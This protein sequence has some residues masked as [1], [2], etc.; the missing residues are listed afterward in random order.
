LPVLHAV[1][2]PRNGAPNLPTPRTVA[3][4]Q[5]NGS[6]R[7]TQRRLY[8]ANPYVA[9]ASATVTTATRAAVQRY[10]HAKPSHATTVATASVVAR[11]AANASLPIRAHERPGEMSS[12][13][14]EA[15]ASPRR[16]QPLLSRRDVHTPGGKRHG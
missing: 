9:N 15:K 16:Q 3:T 14:H 6:V 8:R 4:L 12:F 1:T 10:N 13:K 11:L 5:R 7:A 2:P